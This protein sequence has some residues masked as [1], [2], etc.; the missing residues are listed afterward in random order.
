MSK[1][2]AK[3]LEDC[4]DCPTI[5]SYYSS[6]RQETT[7]NC[8]ETPERQIIPREFWEEGSGF[9]NFCPLKTVPG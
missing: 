3:Q 2:F 5:N 6:H 7:V 4:K 8:T 9:P 1:V